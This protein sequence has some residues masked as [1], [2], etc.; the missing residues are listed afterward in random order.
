MGR[1]GMENGTMEEMGSE[2]STAAGVTSSNRKR[3][4]VASQEICDPWTS[5]K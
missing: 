2:K 5:R 3:V 1:D 4:R